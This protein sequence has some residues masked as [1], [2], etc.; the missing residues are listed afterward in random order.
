MRFDD[1]WIAG[2]GGVIGDLVPVKRAIADGAYSEQ[3]AQSTGVVSVSQ[4]TAA[5]PEMAVTAGRQAVKEAAEY[6]VEIVPDTY[7]L[8]SHSHYQGLDMW[9]AACWIAKELIGTRLQGMPA[10]VQAASNGSL[11]SL[12]IAATALSARPELPNALITI[13]DRFA[14]P[15]DRWYLSPGMVF[16]DGGASVVVTR[17]GGRLRLL[18][19]VSF[20]DTSLEGLA[21]GNE[22]F[23]TEPEPRPDMRKR[24]REFLASGEVSLRDVRARSAAGVTTVVA[25]VLADAG[26]EMSQIDWYAAPFVGR[27]LYR[28][29][30]V[31][32]LA[33]TPANDLS[34]LGLTIG[35]L[36][37]ADALYSLSH[38]V[39]EGL[40]APGGKVL[41]LGTGMGFTFSAA[42][43][44]A[45]AA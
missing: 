5:P 35:H 15:T 43:L 33:E 14:P 29:S 39:K 23:G 40:L 2:T 9:P 3:V 11:A 31:R 37:P 36:G 28:D 13:A 18:S 17:G 12:E 38:L 7:Y 1:I 42:V 25:R 45:D 44:A 30:F 6:G 22:P 27:A 4:A 16:G 20:T 19:L 32:P 34:E 21:R 41:L 10:T 26:L 8:H 24:T